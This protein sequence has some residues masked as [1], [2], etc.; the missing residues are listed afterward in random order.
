MPV[1]SNPAKAERVAKAE[2]AETTATLRDAMNAL[3]QAF[4]DV[5]SVIGDSDVVSL[6]SL[7]AAVDDVTAAV[8]A[9]TAAGG[10]DPETRASEK[11]A[12]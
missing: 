2:S 5:K 3:T 1:E 7:Q 6:V 11:P 8:T 12:S 10:S 9:S 4:A